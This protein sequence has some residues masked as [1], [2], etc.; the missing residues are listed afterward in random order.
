MRGCNSL[1]KLSFVVCLSSSVVC[2]LSSVVCRLLSVVCCLLSVVCRRL[3][4]VACRPSSIVY[5]WSS[6]VGRIA[7]PFSSQQLHPPTQMRM[8]WGGRGLGRS[9]LGGFEP[10][11][12]AMAGGAE[13]G[14]TGL[15]FVAKGARKDMVMRKLEEFAVRSVPHAHH[16]HTAQGTTSKRRQGRAFASYQQQS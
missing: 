6:V 8:G 9:G 7:S 14:T 2:R 10:A 16:N 5:L 11:A 3:S 12:V 13:G 15:G 4:S 1:Q